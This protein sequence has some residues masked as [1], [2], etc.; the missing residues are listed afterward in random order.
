MQKVFNPFESIE[1]RLSYLESLILER[2]QPTTETNPAIFDIDG[3]VNY[4]GNVSKATVYQWM[5]KSFIPYFKIGK[6]AY[7]KRA[8]VDNWML[9]QRKSTRKENADQL[10]K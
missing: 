2:A 5:H 10:T 6:R 4:L 9:T 3:L 8:E 1:Q 7:F